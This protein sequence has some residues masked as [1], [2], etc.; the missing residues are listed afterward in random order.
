MDRLSS[1]I[2]NGLL[3]TLI[4]L[5]AACGAGTGDEARQKA[6]PAQATKNCQVCGTSFVVSRGVVVEDPKGPVT[7]CSQGCAIRIEA[8]L[9][10]PAESRPASGPDSQPDEDR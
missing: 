10:P 3:A 5:A 4:V 7:V 8:W 6:A 2:R 1:I 9:A